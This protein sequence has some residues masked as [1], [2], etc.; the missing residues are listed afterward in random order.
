MDYSHLKTGFFKGKIIKLNPSFDELTELL[1]EEPEKEPK[2]FWESKGVR[3]AVFEFYIENNQNEVFKYAMLLS[4]EKVLS[5]KGSYQYINCLGDTQWVTDESQLWNSFTEFQKV[6]KWSTP[7]GKYERGAKPV[8]KETLGKK[9]YRIA[10]KGEEDL[11]HI[12][13]LITSPNLYDVKTNILLDTEAFFSGDFSQIKLDTDTFHFVAFAYVNNDFKQKLWKKFL[14]VDIMSEL[15]NKEFSSENKKIY[16]N[17]ETQ[18]KDEQF[19]IQGYY[20]LAPLQTFKEEFIK[21]DKVIS[22]DG[23]DY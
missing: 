20:E 21:S 22:D 4:D 17:W 3:K 2:Y 13:K 1:G 18:V 23:P 15:R 19:G 11:L 8:E 6:T 9:E 7:S 14:P 10:K 12:W 16:S 5:S